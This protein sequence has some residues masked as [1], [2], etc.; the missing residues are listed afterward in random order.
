MPKK[1]KIF[2]HNCAKYDMHFIIKGLSH[3]KTNIRNLS[4][5]PY[6]GENFRCL[7]FNS[8]EFVDT[9]AFLQASL[10]QL[11]ADLKLSGHTYPILK[12]TKLCKSGSQ[13]DRNLFEMVLEKSFFPYEYCTSFKRMMATKS[14][15]PISDFYSSLS[16]KT[17][18]KN[19]HE[20]AQSVWNA[21]KCKNL[22]DYTKLYCKIDTILLAE[23]FQA[24]RYKMH[25]F[26]GL[27]P[28]HYISLPAYGYDSMLLIT[29]A[30]LELPTDIDIVHFL[31]KGKRGGVSFIN[32]RHLTTDKKGE[33]LYW[34]FNNLYGACLLLKLPLNQ[35]EWLSVEEV[36]VFDFD[37]DFDGDYGY[38]VE[39]DLKYPKHLHKLHS[40]LPLAPEILEVHFDNLSP[41][42]QSAILQT[43]GSKN[44]RDTKLMST[45]HDRLGYV[46]HI[47]NLKF[48]LELGLELKKVHRILKFRQDYILKPYVE[49]TTEA[50]KNSTSTFESNLFK[51]L[52]S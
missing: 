5:L 20:F 47:K 32:H 17:I 10:S 39:C 14:L 28:A 50:R 40:N 45:F 36:D 44:Y 27:D 15:P 21:F 31:E 43:E 49:M 7:K 23:V 51:K 13:F 9:L 12:Q 38:F 2:V 4:V 35:F 29:G 37:Q 46:L 19:D 24:F 34:D 18:S 16:E 41:Y 8:F 22:V 6:N 3:F 1:L 26:S 33:V 25:A 48:Y 42:A 11:T 30:E 52:V